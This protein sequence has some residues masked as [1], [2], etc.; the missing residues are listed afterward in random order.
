MLQMFFFGPFSVQFVFVFLSYHC[1]IRNIRELVVK[2]SQFPSV[3]L[4][5][6]S[7]PLFLTWTFVKLHMMTLYGTKIQAE[8]L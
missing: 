8:F 6:V 1:I 2:H 3:P 7:V 5:K 4:Y